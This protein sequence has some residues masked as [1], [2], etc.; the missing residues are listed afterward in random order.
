MLPAYRRIGYGL[1][2]Q[3]AIVSSEFTQ[4]YYWLGCW[5][6]HS[7]SCTWARTFLDPTGQVQTEPGAYNNHL[8]QCCGLK[9][10]LVSMDLWLVTVIVYGPEASGHWKDCLLPNKGYSRPSPPVATGD[11]LQLAVAV[12]VGG[13]AVS[14]LLWVRAGS[15][16]CWDFPT[17][18]S[19][20]A[21]E[22]SKVPFVSFFSLGSLLIFRL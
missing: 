4:R 12:W 13:E 10:R 15:R 18:C 1:G 11:C 20:S 16:S 2:E 9:R 21:L 17:S 14:R 5:Q 22:G 19:H 7:W 6:L 3:I 8:S